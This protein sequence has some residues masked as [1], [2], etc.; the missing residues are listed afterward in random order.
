MRAKIEQKI[1]ELQQKPEHHRRRTAL[2]LTAIVGLII[3]A[4]WVF[5]LLPAQLR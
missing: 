5:I 4:V 1:E 2:I 3:V